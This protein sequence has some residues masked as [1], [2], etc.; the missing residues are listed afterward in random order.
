MRRRLGSAQREQHEGYLIPSE[1]YRKIEGTESE[2]VVAV[3]VRTTAKGVLGGG[4][5]ATVYGVEKRLCRGHV[6][7]GP[8]SRGNGR[9]FSP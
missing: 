8:A 9:R 2:H 1:I 3:E 7:R 6:E 4:E 5:V